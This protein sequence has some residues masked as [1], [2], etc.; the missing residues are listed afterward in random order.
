MKSGFSLTKRFVPTWNGNIDANAADQLVAVFNMPTIKDLFD[1]IDVLQTN[2][3]TDSDIKGKLEQNAKVA[4]EAGT[5]LPKYVQLQNAEDFTIEDVV[6]YPPYFA[7][8]V[9]LLFALIAYAQPG[10]G[11]AKNSNG[12]PA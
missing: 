5:Y 11:D 1:I 10:E 6:K 12:L 8:A 9:E 7:L 4:N 3:L 2:G